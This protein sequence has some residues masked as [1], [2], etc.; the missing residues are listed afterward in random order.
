MKR[1]F[2]ISLMLLVISIA[3]YST[4]IT[5]TK[6]YKS[7][8]EFNLGYDLM[9]HI[10]KGPKGELEDKG[11]L[12]QGFII[13]GEYIVSPIN[14]KYS[15]GIGVEYRSILKNKKTEYNTSIPL[16]LSI[17]HL[18]YKDRFYW[19]GRLGYNLTQDASNAKTSGGH[20]MAMGIGKKL[21]YAHVELLWENMGYN[22]KNN[23]GSTGY[24]MENSV[25]IKFGFRLL[26]I[27][28]RL[29][30]SKT[31]PIV[32]P[33]EPKIIK[34]EKTQ[35]V[36]KNIVEVREVYIIKESN[37]NYGLNQYKLGKEAKNYLDK[38]KKEDL[39]GKPYK[40][41]IIAGYTDRSGSSE[42]NKKL[43]EKR[44]NAVANY[45]DLPKN[46]VEVKGLGETH[47]LGGNP[48]D[49]RRVEIEVRR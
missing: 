42:Y 46:M 41:V 12:N 18:F 31:K 20:Y 24:N 8:L 6:K 17:S 21:G 40:R 38:I 9:R 49:D 36:V 45:L 43:S 32:R 35:V 27:Y 37:L 26:D 29:A 7:D 11:S 5:E 33:I 13:G 22:F 19:V 23:L 48:R 4:E 39:E 16:F 44:A 10:G 28:D 34:E 3:T 2:I 14:S 15:Y 30:H 25:G 1:N 47:L